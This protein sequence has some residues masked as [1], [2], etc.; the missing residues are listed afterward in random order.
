MLKKR[1]TE[2][3]VTGK[4][5]NTNIRSSCLFAVIV[6]G[7]REVAAEGADNIFVEVSGQQS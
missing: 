7:Q 3:A 5:S 6:A 2:L 1:A 4:L